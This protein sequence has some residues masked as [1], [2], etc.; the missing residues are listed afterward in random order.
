[1]LG[2]L[3]MDIDQV[4]ECYNSL[5]EQVFSKRKRWGDGKF[6]ATTLEA[7]IKPVVQCALGDSESP[8]FEGDV[9]GAC[10]T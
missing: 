2:H 5:V 8:L 4:I 10:R 7:V 1:M 3:R 6:K 9:D